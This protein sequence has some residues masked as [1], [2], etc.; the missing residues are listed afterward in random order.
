MYDHTSPSRTR[1]PPPDRGRRR[2]GFE[3]PG[4]H[5]VGVAIVG[6]GSALGVSLYPLPD[7]GLLDWF[8]PEQETSTESAKVVESAFLN[9]GIADSAKLKPLDLVKLVAHNRHFPEVATDRLLHL[10]TTYGSP[11]VVRSRQ[12][13]DS[14][15]PLRH[16][17]PSSMTLLDFLK[18]N[19]PALSVVADYGTSSPM[20]FRSWLCPRHSARS[21]AATRG[22]S[23]G[24]C[25]SPSIFRNHG[26][27]TY[28]GPCLGTHR[29]SG[30]RTGS[31]QC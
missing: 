22:A 2:G 8:R 21:G 9:V 3:R 24:T 23:L 29:S 15:D 6:G 16:S 5:A 20:S 27:G 13:L 17:F 19:T 14:L 26:F 12:L 25:R 10:V 11:D 7:G 28:R 4:N 30:F 31:A 18:Q 1:T